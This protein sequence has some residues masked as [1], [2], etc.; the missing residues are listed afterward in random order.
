MKFKTGSTVR[1]KK[2]LKIEYDVLY[3]DS[4]SK[5]ESV[6]TAEMDEFN[7]N[8]FKLKRYESEE[9]W[10]YQAPN[11]GY[12]TFLEDWLELDSFSAY[13]YAMEIIK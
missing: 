11:H 9:G 10:V 12:W 1:I 8:T 7:N 5:M 6:W 2:P 3:V 4:T 13:E